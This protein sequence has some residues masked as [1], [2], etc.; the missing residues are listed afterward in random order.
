MI[1]IRLPLT[2]LLRRY[3][4]LVHAVP[5]LEGGCA[6]HN[7]FFAVQTLLMG[8]VGNKSMQAIAA[9]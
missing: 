4:R 8:W 6:H 7:L 5:V 1:W 2:A 3:V 9:F